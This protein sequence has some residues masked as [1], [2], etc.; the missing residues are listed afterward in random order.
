MKYLEIAI[1]TLTVEIFDLQGPCFLK[2]IRFSVLRTYTCKN[3]ADAS[4]GLYSDQANNGING[5]CLREE[6]C[7]K[8]ILLS[9]TFSDRL[10]SIKHAWERHLDIPVLCTVGG[11][12][13]RS[14]SKC[15]R[16]K[17]LQV[18]RRAYDTPDRQKKMDNS[19][20][21]QHGCGEAGTLTHLLWHCPS[22]RSF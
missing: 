4:T 21:C 16:Y 20:L 5:N 2:L 12:F 10:S 22:V 15:V 9:T 1:R 3:K 13:K 7:F 6:N 19:N 14:F 11:C 17:S 8:T 18:V